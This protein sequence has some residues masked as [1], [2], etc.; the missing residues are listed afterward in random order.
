MIMEL[1][2]GKLSDL[3]GIDINLFSQI[4][5]GLKHMHTSGYVHHD[6]NPQNILIDRNQ[7][8]KICNFGT[9]KGINWI[10]KGP[11]GSPDYQAPEMYSEQ[12]YCGTQQ[13]IFSLGVLL[14]KMYFGVTSDANY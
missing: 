14:E 7:K 10:T 4:C 1:C 8:L 3:L 9:V 11:C 13:D 12:G 2:R 6:L 5:N